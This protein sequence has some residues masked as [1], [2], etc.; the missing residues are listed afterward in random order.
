M[1]GLNTTRASLQLQKGEVENLQN[2]RTR[3]FLNWSKRKGV[4]PI[5]SSPT[6]ILGIFDLEFDQ[7]VIPLFIAGDTL[8]FYPSTLTFPVGQINDREYPDSLPSQGGLGGGGA[9]VVGLDPYA[10][11]DPLDEDESRTVLFLLEP[12]MRAVQ[13]RGLRVP[14]LSFTWPNRVFDEFGNAINE[15]P[16]TQPNADYYPGAVGSSQFPP[17]NFYKH[18]LAWNDLKNGNPSGTRA[19]ELINT[20]IA[21]LNT[22]GLASSYVRLIE[23]QSSTVD[24]AINIPQWPLDTTGSPSASPV[25]FRQ[26][27]V[28]CK[29]AV[30]LLE[31]IEIT[32]SG[33]QGQ[34]SK[35]LLDD[36]VSFVSCAIAL[37]DMTTLYLADPYFAEGIGPQVTE[38]S[39]FDGVNEWKAR[40]N[41][42]RAYFT[43]NLTAYPNAPTNI[44]LKVN[45]QTA[46]S[47]NSPPTTADSLFHIF[48]T[49]TG[50]GTYTSPL[51]GNQT[52]AFSF[53]SCPIGGQTKGWGLVDQVAIVFP[54]FFYTV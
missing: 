17:N 16:P 54:K 13:E 20:I 18:D 51:I 5:S 38:F 35:T 45:P 36:A 14:V 7:L 3:P 23:G 28:K 41:N 6:P 11:D 47:S 27:L 30:R 8:T 9:T 50:G 4:F 31:A 43:A 2:L 24:W 12:T 26:M 1:K 10:S 52:A 53:S 49:G 25:T 39:S 46:G 44:Y 29:Q 21:A 22:P 34:E 15:A 42:T 37:S 33:Y 48:A 19:A 32:T 40:L